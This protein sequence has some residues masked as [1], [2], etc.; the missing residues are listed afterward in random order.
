MHVDD[1]PKATE[2]Y[3]ILEDLGYITDE[4][5]NA[6]LDGTWELYEGNDEE[7][8]DDEEDDEEEDDEE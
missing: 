6:M 5:E 8:E 4:T 2:L 7:E 1:H 3:K